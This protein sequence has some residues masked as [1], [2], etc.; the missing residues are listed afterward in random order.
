MPEPRLD[1][2]QMAMTRRALLRLG[3]V[4]CVSSCTDRAATSSS[5]PTP[6]PTPVPA[7]AATTYR[8]GALIGPGQYGTAK[9][10]TKF[11]LSVVD[12]DVRPRKARRVPV[13][14]FA[15]GVVPNP[16][17]PQTAVLFEK[18]GKGSCEVDLV[19]GRV[20]R[21]IETV[22]ERQFYGHGAF[23]PDGARLFATETVTE[24]DY[25]GVIAVR[26][27]KTFEPL[28]TFPSHGSSPHDCRLIDDGKVLVVANGGHAYDAGVPASVTW[29]EV[30]SGKLLDKVDVPDPKLNAGH[31][32]LTGGDLVIVSAPRDGL[33]DFAEANGGVTL[34]PNGGRATTMH[35]PAPVTSLLKGETLSVCLHEPSRVAAC[36]TPRGDLVTFWDLDTLSLVKAHVLPKARGV[37]LTLD[38]QH[39]VIS[40]GIVDVSFVRTADLELV[41]G[42]AFDGSYLTGSHVITYDLP[43]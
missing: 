1:P 14:F 2:T 26:D 9:G 42:E 15:H 22:A 17:R 27:G 39:F 40:H 25:E 16:A 4:L 37:T 10:E 38:Q 34:R 24:G 3:A 12:L 43:A 35:D 28:G 32:A 36:T 6:T 29:V 33:P 5:A 23:L 31:F 11:V 18:K 8:H 19:T 13:D 20:L 21:S 41:P 30:S 7:P